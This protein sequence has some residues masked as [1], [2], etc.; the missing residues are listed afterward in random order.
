MDRDTPKRALSFL[1][2]IFTLAALLPSGVLIA[3]P[4]DKTSPVILPGT[5]A[6]D[7]S[8]DSS[9]GAS[10]TVPIQVSPGTAGMQPAVFLQY[11]S[12]AGSN[13]MGRGWSLGG[14]SSITRG[15]KN[16]Q[17]DG[18][19]QGVMLT[20]ADALFLDGQKL[21]YVQGQNGIRYY[22]TLINNHSRIERKREPRTNLDYFVVYTKAGLIMEYRQLVKVDDGRVLAWLN[23]EIQ[24]TSGNYVKFNYWV[25]T[26]GEYGIDHIE[27]TGNHKTGQTPYASLKFEY[28][29][30]PND[31]KST[32]YILGNKI[33]TTKKLKSIASYFGADNDSG[34]L[35]RKYDL[36]YKLSSGVAKEYFLHRIQ[37]SGEAGQK[38]KPTEFTYADIFDT[39][40]ADRWPIQNSTSLPDMPIATQ[41]EKSKAFAVLDVNGDGHKDIIYSEELDKLYTKV[42]LGS[43][44]TWTESTN[45]DYRP[46]FALASPVNRDWRQIDLDGNGPSE[47]LLGSVG[48]FD[49]E[50]YQLINKVWVRKEQLSAIGEINQDVNDL[51]FIDFDNDGKRDLLAPSNED[52]AQFIAF[53]QVADEWQPS[54][55]FN[56]E[57]SALSVLDIDCD[58]KNDLVALQYDEKD[59]RLLIQSYFSIAGEWQKND[60]LADIPID[61]V[62]PTAFRALV[63][64]ID[65]DGCNDLILSFETETGGG[66]YFYKS[67]SNGLEFQ[68]GLSESLPIQLLGKEDASVFTQL[69]SSAPPELIVTDGAGATVTFR[70]ESNGQG[71]IEWTRW[72]IDSSGLPYE[73]N[74]ARYAKT[75]IDVDRDNVDE[76]LL[77]YSDK[78]KFDP[79]L[80]EITDSGWQ[81]VANRQIPENIAKFDTAD[82]GSQFV[83]LNGDGL[84]DLVTASKSFRNTG[85]GWAE[86]PGTNFKPPVRIAIENGGD[87]GT[88]I[89]DVDGDGLVD[90]VYAYQEKK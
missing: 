18:A 6:G 21:V 37:E 3:D 52:K 62:N 88:R 8:V 23:S 55:S 43:T 66:N 24:D 61:G 19:V 74:A 76:L 79:K 42:F 50:I 40:P 89:L 17:D 77:F 86:F 85:A 51:H 45:N 83:D 9:G 33:A 28:D 36:T 90:F 35:F 87:S 29:P 64:D 60:Q 80:F 68:T 20:D 56:L 47:I 31:V 14:L 48:D 26:D 12:Q 81:L 46:G 15:R 22:R 75:K 5:L 38:H 27:Y 13:T 53:R 72:N 34:S 65:G 82:L 10:Y 39:S 69:N 1:V 71:V 70:Q 30:L 7:F 32:Q 84:Q 59:R 44:S 54:P 16:L 4:G 11:S 2:L 67:T 78:D 73:F 41:G 25:N 57:A 58:R 63:Q 49:A